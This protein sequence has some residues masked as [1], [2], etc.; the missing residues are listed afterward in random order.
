LG[1]DPDIYLYDCAWAR[2]GRTLY[3]QRQRRDQ[4]GL[5]LLAIDPET[6]RSRVILSE[7]DPTWVDLGREFRPLAD[8]T[9]LWASPRSG[10]R[11]LYL[12]DRDGKPIRAVTSGNWRIAFTGPQM[13][14][15]ASPVVAVDEA[16]GEVYFIASK[17]TPLEQHLYVVSYRQPGEP[18]KIT[19]GRGWWWPTMAADRPTGFVA[20]YSDPTTPPQTAIYDLAGR[21]IAWI[22]ENRLGPGHPYA[23]Y[24]DH[25]PTVEYGTIQA[26]NGSDLHYLLVKPHDF[27]ATR[28]YPVI[29]NP[30]GGPGVQSVKREWRGVVEQ[31]LAQEGY[32]VFKLDNRGSANR[33]HAFEHAIYHDLGDVM[34]TDQLAGVRFLRS[35]SY[36]DPD[37]IGST[38]W[39]FG[40]Y[41]TVRMM[42]E[43]GSHIRAGA[44]G[45]TP[46]DFRLYDTHYTE[47]FLGTPQGD[48]QGYESG[49]LLPRAKHLEGNLLLLQGLSDDNVLLPNFT[50][51][52]AELQKAGKVFETAVYPGQGHVPRGKVMLT[53]MWKTQLDLFERTLKGGSPPA[54]PGTPNAVGSRVAPDAPQRT[55]RASK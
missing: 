52:V 25:K 20:T 29:L 14:P 26:A 40:A 48:P 2:D 7:T 54:T 31:V 28:R 10:W 30:Y 44:A 49:A 46:S 6:G 43:P 32:L 8:G 27:D 47:R 55:V 50:A 45:G 33:D 1:S 39:S 5:D 16:R 41:A 37:R 18:R 22:V 23:P 15:D 3:A 13:P 42:T 21:R 38:G 34:L 9:F 17:E 12:H 51:L 24:L 36:V 19:N 53:H 35:L 4:K 11:H